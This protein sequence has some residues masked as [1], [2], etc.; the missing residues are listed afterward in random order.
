MSSTIAAYPAPS[1]PLDGGEL[2]AG[3]QDG[4]QIAIPVATILRGID[5]APDTITGYY[6]FG[7]FAVGDVASKEILLDHVAAAPH[8]LA[9]DFAGCVASVGTPPATFWS[10]ELAVNGQAIGALTIGSDGTSRFVNSF[11]RRYSIAVGDIV[12]V[13]APEVVDPTIAR[14]RFTLSGVAI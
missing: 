12:T 10:A 4:R 2:L 5:P 9:A 8:V 1:R 7:G 13:I 3:F 11:D 14:L 6:R